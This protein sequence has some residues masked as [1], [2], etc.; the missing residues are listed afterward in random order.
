MREPAGELTIEPDPLPERAREDYEQILKAELANVTTNMVGTTLHL[1]NVAFIHLYAD[2]GESS[3]EIT[4]G[5]HG[6]VCDD[7]SFKFKRLN[8]RKRSEL[9]WE[10]KHSMARQSLLLDSDSDN[11]DEY[12]H[13]SRLFMDNQPLFFEPFDH[14]MLKGHWDGQRQKKLKFE[15]LDIPSPEQRQIL[16][17]GFATF[18]NFLKQ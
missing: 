15:A 5:L 4:Y 2:Y 8:P 6:E 12:Y 10:V 11:Y 9:T 13:E 16:L 14:A 1:A 17:G 18:L 3:A 7:F